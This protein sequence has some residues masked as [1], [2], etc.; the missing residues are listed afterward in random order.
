MLTRPAL[1]Q[2]V[3]EFPKDTKWAQRQGEPSGAPSDPA[4]SPPRLWRAVKDLLPSSQIYGSLLRTVA[5]TTQSPGPGTSRLR[6]GPRNSHFNK[7]H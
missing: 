1:W 7:N 2:G 6:A 4:D 5:V 3:C